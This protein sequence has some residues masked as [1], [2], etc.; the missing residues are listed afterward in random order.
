[1]N[2]FVP[3][4]LWIYFF[5]C[6]YKYIII[7]VNFIQ[8]HYVFLKMLWMLVICNSDFV[9]NGCISLPF[10][11]MKKSRSRTINFSWELTPAKL[12]EVKPKNKAP[13]T[14]LFKV[15][16][17]ATPIGYGSDE[18]AEKM[19]KPYYEGT[20]SPSQPFQNKC[21]H[22]VLM[23]D[24]HICSTIKIFFHNLLSNLKPNY[25]PLCEKF[26]I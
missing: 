15:L 6:V 11:N 8:G 25:S 2:F 17:Q 19:K 5:L 10:L 24:S 12:H 1:M 26:R 14:P 3:L 20:S 23:R 22:R 9:L 16:K 13:S 4:Y 18:V 21:K 7:E